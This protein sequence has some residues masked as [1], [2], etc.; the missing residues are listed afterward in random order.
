M[1]E[2]KNY[3]YNLLKLSQEFARLGA[4]YTFNDKFNNL[5]FPFLQ[6]EIKPLLIV[7][8]PGNYYYEGRA[9]AILNPSKHLVNLMN[10]NFSIPNADLKKLVN[11]QCDMMMDFSMSIYESVE[12]KLIGKYRN[13][14]PVSAKFKSEEVY[15]KLKR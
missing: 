8:M 12:I 10:E 2:V 3:V 1:N 7:G 11:K 14:T 6:G 15:L 13:Q 4:E 5:I 9:I